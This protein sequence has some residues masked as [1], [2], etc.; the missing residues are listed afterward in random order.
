MILSIK[1]AHTVLQLESCE[2][3]HLVWQSASHKLLL[4]VYT[5]CDPSLIDVMPSESLFDC[6]CRF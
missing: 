3:F 2:P 5:C 1:A 6:F 4:A